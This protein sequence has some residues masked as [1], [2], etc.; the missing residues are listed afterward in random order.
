MIN[1]TAFDGKEDREIER[2]EKKREAIE[3]AAAVVIKD[4]VCL[5]NEVSESK[6]FPHTF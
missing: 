5:T 3:S 2:K 4:A 6:K 1:R